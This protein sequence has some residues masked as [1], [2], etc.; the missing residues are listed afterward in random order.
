MSAIPF[1]IV[2]AG[3][4]AEFFLR[5][6]RACPD[7]FSITGM[8]VR[9]AEKGRAVEEK[10]GVRA[11]RSLDDLLSAT[12]PRFV[13]TSVPGRANPEIIKDLVRRGVPALSET[14]PAL[15]LE[16][17]VDLYETVAKHNGKVQ[18]AEQ[19]HLQPLH[20]ARLACAR[21]GRLGAISQAQVSY[22]GAYHGVSLIRRFLGVRFEDAVIRSMIFKSP[23]VK[24]PD[25]KGPPAKEEIAADRP[26]AL[27]WFDFG[28]RF[29]ALDFVGDQYFSWIRD[30][31]MLIRGERGEMTG[32]GV[33]YLKDYLTPV[34]LP[35]VRQVGGADGNLE[36]NYLKGVQL[37]DEWLYRNPF[38]PAPLTDEELAIA[39]CLAAM[40]ET[41][42]TGK[43]FY[44]LAEACQ[45]QYLSLIADKAAKTGETVRTQPQAWAG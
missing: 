11:F 33:V 8:V 25:R 32:D 36:G 17:M 40:D 39:G 9:N 10:W 34:S 22:A 23:I 41:A 37:G 4:R 13:V 31:R 44:S 21:S 14:P 35:F 29:G 5:I 19:Y 15:T 26:Q 24:G 30:K 3:W 27:A 1:A 28:G 7:Q 2:G 42:R 6:V 18:V 45:D 38:A 16:A 12:A 20:F 43:D